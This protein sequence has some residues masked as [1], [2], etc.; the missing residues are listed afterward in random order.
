MRIPFT[1]FLV[2]LTVW[3]ARAHGPGEG[4]ADLVEKISSAVVFIETAQTSNEQPNLFREFF[5]ERRQNEEAPRGSGSGFSGSSVSDRN[6]SSASIT[7]L[8]G[9]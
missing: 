4:Y 5:R 8:E 2:S 3:Q 9:A 6:A 1:I 7:L